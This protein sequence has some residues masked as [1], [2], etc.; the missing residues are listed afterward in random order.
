MKSLDFTCTRE[1]ISPRVP[2]KANTHR[3]GR[4]RTASDQYCLVLM[5]DHILVL[6][7][8]CLSHLNQLNISLDW[9]DL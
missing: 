3:F 1:I 8:V 7:A 5:P 6:N 2:S 4:G 9:N